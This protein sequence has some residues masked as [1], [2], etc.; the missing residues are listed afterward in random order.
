MRN[1]YLLLLAALLAHGEIHAQ[2]TNR[3]LDF[4]PAIPSDYVQT[5]SSP[6][7]G[8][9]N[10]TVEARFLC[11][12]TGTNTRRLFAFGGG[13]NNRFEVA[14]SGGALRVIRQVVGGGITTT[15]IVSPNVRN[16]LWHH[17]AATRNGTT[18]RLYLNGT[19]V[20]TS[21]AFV[22]TLN[23][24][25]FRIGASVLSTGATFHWD[26]RIDELRVWNVERTS[27]Q[28]NEFRLCW[29][30]CPAT[31]LMAYYHFDQGVPGGN[32]PTVTVLEDC[33]N[34]INGTLTA[35]TLTGG[36]SNWICSNDT[37]FLNGPC[38]TA[39]FTTAQ[40][41]CG[42]VD[43]NNSTTGNFTYAWAFGDGG[44]STQTSPSHTY[45]TSGTYTV[46]LTATSAPTGTPCSVQQ[47]ITVTADNV[48]PIV[49]CRNV[50]INYSAGVVA[51]I[52]SVVHLSSSD[53]CCSI[54]TLSLTGQT[55][56]D[57]ADV[58]QPPRTVTLI[59]TDCNNNTATCTAS[60][61][62]I[63]VQIPTA[64]CK[65]INIGIGF[66]GSTSI[67]PNDVD[68]GTTDN[69][70]PL[71]LSV[72]PGTF[73]CPAQGCEQVHIVTLRAEDCSGNTSTCTAQVTV[74]DVIPPVWVNCPPSIFISAA[75]GQCSAVI[76]NGASAT[77]NCDTSPALSFVMSGA[78]TASGLGNG[79]GMACNVGLTTVVCTASD[80]CGLTS[81][82]SFNVRV[83]DA[84]PPIVNCP[85]S[86]TVQ[87]SI[88]T[89][90][91]VV[92][93]PAIVPTDN[94]PGVTLVQVAGLPSG[95]VF[96]CG[97]TTTVVFLARD[98]SGNQ[99]T[100]SFS[101]TVNCPPCECGSFTNMTFS[102]QGGPPMSVQCGDF[103][104]IACPVI[105][106]TLTLTG[107]FACAPGGDCTPSNIQLVNS[108][109]T[110]IGTGSISG[111][112]FTWSFDGYF[113]SNPGWYELYLRGD[114][115]QQ[116]CQC[117]VRFTVPD[118]PCP[119]RA[120]DFDG[121][122]DQVSLAPAPVT[123]NSDFTAEAIFTSTATGTNT[124][125]SGNFRR[126]ITLSGPGSRFEVGECGGFLNLYWFDGSSSFGPTQ[127]STVNVRDGVCRHLAAVRSGD[128]VEVFLNG[129]SIFTG[130]GVN[131]L[132]TN[133]FRLGQWGGPLAPGENWQGTVD[134]VRLWNYPRT[135]AQINAFQNCPLLGNESG[136][137]VY[138]PMEQGIP[139]GNNPTV[140]QAIDATAGIDNG[141]LNNFALTGAHS[142]WV[143][144][145]TGFGEAC[146]T[147]DSLC[148]R[149]VVTCFSGIDGTSGNF[150][151]QN[152]NG[153]VL[154]MIDTRNWATA[155]LGSNWSLVAG[156]IYHH[157]TWIAQNLGEVFGLT[158]DNSQ[159]IYVTG[160]T[161]YGGGY[162]WG[163]NGPA[164]IYRINANTGAITN[165]VA[166]GPYVSGTAFIPN[167]G[168]G[169]G[170]ICYNEVHNLLYVTNFY[171]GMI[172]RVDPV[173]GNVLSRFDPFAPAGAP[174][175]NP[176]FAP[177][178]DRPWGIGYNRTENRIYFGLWKENTNTTSNGQYNE[179]YSLALNGSGDFS[180]VEVLEKTVTEYTGTNDNSS[181]ISDITFSDTDKKMLIGQ[182]TMFGS[183]IPSNVAY[184]AHQSKVIEYEKVAGLWV[185]TVGHTSPYQTGA[186]L[187]FKVGNPGGGTNSAGGVAY[188]HESFSSNL[189]LECD[190]SVWCTG[191]A[192]STTH[193]TGAEPWI[194]GLTGFAATGGSNSTGVL[195]DFNNNTA[196]WDKSQIGDVEVFHCVSCIELPPCDS[197]SA[198]AEHIPPVTG[199]TGECCYTIHL[200]N[201]IPNFAASVN[202]QVISGGNLFNT[203][204][205]PAAGWSINGFNGG[206][207]VSIIHSSG[208][209]PVGAFPCGVICMSNLTAS[210]QVIEVQ[211]LD[212]DGN[213]ICK[214]ELTLECEFCISI[215]Q[216]SI[217][218]DP[219]TGGRTMTFCVHVASTSAFNVHS[220]VLMPPANV[221]VTPSSFALPN[222]PPGS[223]YCTLTT[224]ITVA[225]G[226]NP[227][228]VC[229]GFTAHEQD[230]TTGAPPAECCKIE[231]CFD[232]PD[233]C[234][235]FA[236]AM[237]VDTSD[238]NCCWKITV[239]QPS[240]TAQFV[241]LNIIPVP[242]SPVTFESIGFDPNWNFNLDPGLQTVTFE[243]D[244]AAALPANIN[245]PVICFD[246][247]YGSP[248][249]QLLEVVWSTR[250]EIL[251]LD[252]LEFSCQ[253]DTE[254]VALTPLSLTCSQPLPGDNIY[255]VVI[256]NPWSSTL[257]IVPTHVAVV[258]V[259]PS[260][261]LVGSGI[262]PIGNLPPGTS[263]VVPI[264]FN[265]LPGTVV[266]FKLNL[267]RNAKPGIFEEC[268]VT[269][270]T[271]CVTLRNCG[272]P[273]RPQ[274][275][276][277]YPNPT[278][279]NFTL[280]FSDTG[281]PPLG[282]VRVR[283]VVG[284]LVREEA[285]PVG[286][287]KHEVEMPELSSGLYFVEFIEN[288]TRVWSRKLSLIR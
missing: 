43:F 244:P 187:K 105:G 234:P 266:C 39:T 214:D 67:T 176:A 145:C 57:C 250:E 85:P 260:G 220:I 88:I 192:L 274:V 216:D 276:N 217:I 199:Q 124:S 24:T 230:V 74:R 89:G 147:M 133:L 47:T 5:T 122:D 45:T 107:T 189:P 79:S 186:Q 23:T 156:N 283:D 135:A 33:N 143:C 13:T 37:M 75:P 120:L 58:C 10:F 218:C 113:I 271:F 247:P 31:N 167:N 90:G 248:V 227:D 243:L 242:G 196:S 6:V 98:L 165:L 128:Q 40:Q 28:I 223:T 91:A 14:E 254:C 97:G 277:L 169:L 198:T 191:D 229:I 210:Q 188:G 258:E 102:Q 81:T 95:S 211:Y 121:V 17:L 183:I 16:G 70:P 240:G 232:L 253:P 4:D 141:I 259:T 163:P 239:N 148:G 114:C 152:L 267:Y 87:G 265:G 212:A 162:V 222:M 168:A 66:T 63:D 82:C 224:T 8:N 2:C 52:P 118:C 104:P 41:G 179:I 36:N 80:E 252:T 108:D 55:T 272:E 136:L 270:D 65:S 117:I 62:V 159:H 25:T 279:G 209:I 27:A 153:Y 174:S 171:D 48:P 286:L 172:Y 54:V 125:C 34:Q 51:I 185:P 69:C 64:V 275:V 78:T 139:I 207:S 161:L 42:D 49:T 225:R 61:T 200:S 86:V 155:P 83:I 146:G 166:T 123:G 263:A 175:G 285:V 262:Y 284:R 29:A 213:V 100:C 215:T 96:P 154:A 206:T 116:T 93:W 144:G 73:T 131:P 142:N 11:T 129:V 77:D 3:C 251:C 53:N 228:D 92:T 261:V 59:A 281:S 256:T 119:N 7:T 112:S 226:T 101:V 71:T 193:G 208:L 20:Y 264:H 32:N 195:I 246:V 26:G 241:T 245:L 151:T 134:E 103:I 238:G 157:N 257:T 190:Q 273:L 99:S 130:S 204:V 164:G 138:W 60:V 170:N 109:G 22:G 76:Q 15:N 205:T 249:P 181:P 237:P 173:T 158:L 178:G 221:T 106:S 287:F 202:F 140:T 94:C 126:L 56:F 231:Q 288:Q 30:T 282:L 50:T 278:R 280:V 150:R 19:Q 269:E 38:C 46:T 180:G 72:L 219:T 132:N 194:Y 115:G 160:T 197:I 236:T 84:Q 268:C 177:L 35:F 18:L 110:P 111:T 235:N 137:L 203:D 1:I 201:N 233:C 149:A 68:A 12:S 255:T 184:W 44:T 182:H 9:S 127:L 21:A